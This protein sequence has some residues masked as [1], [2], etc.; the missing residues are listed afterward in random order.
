MLLKEDI[1]TQAHFAEKLEEIGFVVT[2]RNQD[3]EGEYLNIKPHG[4]KKGVNLKEPVFLS[5]FVSMTKNDKHQYLNRDDSAYWQEGDSRYQAS[6]KHHQDLEHWNDTRCYELRYVHRRNRDKYKALTP[7]QKLEFL[8]QKR[9][10]QHGQRDIPKPSIESI[11]RSLENSRETLRTAGRDLHDAQRNRGGIESGGRNFVNRRAARAAIAHLKRHAGN[12]SPALSK[13]EASNTLDQIMY[14]YQQRILPEVSLIKKTID[15]NKLLAALARTH[16]VVIDKYPI[17][18]AQDGSPRIVCGNRNNNVSDF[19]T[20]EMHLSWK[21]AKQYLE[22]QYL[23]QKGIV[24]KTAIQNQAE[25]NLIRAAWRSQLQIER[26][27]RQE[28]IAQYRIEKKAIRADSSLSKEDK[29]VALS[30][31]QMNKVIF[32]MQFRQAS[33]ETRDALKHYSNPIKEHNDM[34]EEIGT[35]VAH[36][37]AHYQHNPKQDQ[38]YYVT[39]EHNGQTKAIW[40]KGLESVMRE[41]NIK[42]GDMVKLSQD[43]QEDVIVTAKEEQ[44]DGTIKRNEIEAIRNKWSV[45]KLEMT[46]EQQANKQFHI[47]VKSAIAQHQQYRD[48]NGKESIEVLMQSEA[49]AEALGVQAVDLGIK[50]NPFKDQAKALEKAFSQSKHD[51]QHHKESLIMEKTVI[52][53][54]KP[55]RKQTLSSILDKN[56]EASRLLIHYPKLKELGINAQSITKT[57]KGDRIQYSEKQLPVTQLIKE[58]H[59]LKPKE[60]TEA[61]KAIYN[62]QEKDKQRT[63]EYKNKYM[64]TQRKTISEMDAERSNKPDIETTNKL[65]QQPSPEKTIEP[66]DKDGRDIKPLPPKQFDESITHETN[67]EGHVTYYLGK[68]KLVTDRGKSVKIENNSDKA[69]EIGLRLSI[70]KYGKHLDIQGTKEYK[71]QVID[72]AVKNKLDITFKDKALNEQ[73]AKRK[74]EFEKG[75]NIIAKAESKHRDNNNPQE[76]EQQ[77]VD[78]KQ[79]SKGWDR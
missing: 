37:K 42:D 23:H 48:S 63:L 49:K 35:V 19:L 2:R 50:E 29:Q 7:E 32:D 15:P 59:Q 54:N 5:P 55:E 28:Y 39:L 38:S 36:G 75:E 74:Q 10:E 26:E 66:K 51:Y 16:G 44:P 62:T 33:R 14:D 25:P 17:T 67:K 52:E 20:K 70:E 72:V 71:D 3:K 8:T 6:Q 68:D 24:P 13:R 78:Q 64:Q 45:T 77:A 56:L 1:T 76:K 18:Y 47:D 11:G 12:Q 58:T 60:I 34:R 46:P 40:G 21:E 41:R 53:N 22:D 27:T 61:L 43:G 73:F 57:D 69:V 79:P 65:R 9:N 4:E 31:A 30:I